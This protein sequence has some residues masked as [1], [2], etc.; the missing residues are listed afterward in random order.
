MSENEKIIKMVYSDANIPL[1]YADK[2]RDALLKTEPMKVIAVNYNPPEDD[3][4]N[5]VCTCPRCNNEIRFENL[6]KDSY[7]EICGQLMT[8]WDELVSTSYR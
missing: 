3:R 1:S 4:P 7:C 6:D 8:D 5:I 2:I